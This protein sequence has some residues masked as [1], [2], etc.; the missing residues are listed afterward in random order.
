M[1]IA[2]QWKQRKPIN[3]DDVIYT[4]T[5]TNETPSNLEKKSKFGFLKR[6]NG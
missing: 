4:S 1:G 3:Q 5:K 6:N 2:D